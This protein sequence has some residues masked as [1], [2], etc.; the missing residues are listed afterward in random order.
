MKR[1][2][3]LTLILLLAIPIVSKAQLLES[4]YKWPTNSG[5]F[6][7][8]T[9]G[10][11]RSAHFHAG[12]DIKTWGMEGYP[13]YATRDGYLSQLAITSHGYGKVIYLKHLDGSYSVYAH[14]SKFNKQFQEL[15]DQLRFPNYSYEMGANYESDSIYV[16]QGN[17]IGYTGSTGIGPPH[18][19][20]EIRNQNNEPINPLKAGFKIKD[21][22]QPIFRNLLVEPMLPS[23]SIEG[24]NL[25]K[26]FSPSRI[27][28][29]EYSYGTVKTSGPI[30][31]NVHVYDGADDVFNKYAIYEMYVVQNEDTLFGQKVSTFK[32]EQSSTMMLDRIPAPGA[33]AK[34][35]HRLY[36]HH[37][38][39]HPFVTHYDEYFDIKYGETYTIIAK[40][41]FGNTST[42]VV[43]FEEE[44]AQIDAIE[45]YDLGEIKNGLWFEN[46]ISLAGNSYIDLAQS[47]YGVLWDTT[48]NQRLVDFKN[49][50]NTFMA[51]ITPDSQTTF[52]TPDKRVKFYYP[53]NTYHS[54]ISI[55]HNYKVDEDVFE[56][57]VK[58]ANVNLNKNIEVYFYLGNFMD[59]YDK[60]ALYYYN[61]G[62]G[63][64][65]LVPSRIKG[66][67]LAASLPGFGKYRVAEDT[68]KPIIKSVRYSK[69][70]S[71]ERVIIV[72]VDDDLSGID[73]RTAIFKVNG[74]QGIAEYDYEKKRFT[75]YNPKVRLKAKNEV[76]FSIK[77]RAGN[78]IERNFQL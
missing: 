63:R 76:Y 62:N 8:S 36:L 39:D 9:F 78:L 55:L 54:P 68:T 3:Y 49:D 48:S 35:Y 50:A 56:I 15:A 53:K 22:I 60:A 52:E 21:N 75:Y 7:S 71:G 40:D 73:F 14:L 72:D 6:L 42:A 33:I 67:M 37:A 61:S 64:L 1:K 45:H 11:T 2:F 43:E 26:T 58:S 74:Q 69:L 5:Q 65:S 51:R 46:H 30:G 77:D 47:Q 66:G 20:F 34:N 25:A 23:S 29:G 12:L 10:E 18:L 27:K 70:Y 28:A 44:N 19:H 41:Y 24:K 32:F 16:R 38:A 4:N 13:V 59:G 31:L 57:E 17:I